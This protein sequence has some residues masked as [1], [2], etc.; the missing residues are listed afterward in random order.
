MALGAERFS[1]GDAG[2]EVTARASTGDED[3]QR[4]GHDGDA[5]GADTRV[6]ARRTIFPRVGANSK[7]NL[8]YQSIANAGWDP[9]FENIRNR[10]NRKNLAGRSPDW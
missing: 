6:G 5:K 4:L 1:D 9:E 3:F 8:K 10:T 7:A 2:E